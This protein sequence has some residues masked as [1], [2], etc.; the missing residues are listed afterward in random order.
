MMNEPHGEPNI[1]IA[2]SEALALV[3][4]L[5]TCGLLLQI[6][7]PMLALGTRNELS[8]DLH[9]AHDAVY[10]AIVAQLTS[11]SSFPGGDPS[12]LA[13]GDPRR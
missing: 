7:P 2:L 5:E 8:D 11:T 10:S 12:M 4:L 6:M 3:S 13:R 1:G 9:R